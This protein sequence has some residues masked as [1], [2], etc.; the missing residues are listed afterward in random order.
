[1]NRPSS[2]TIAAEE[3]ARFTV[4]EFIE[5]A[6][7]ALGSLPGK[8]ELVDGVIVR[9]SPANYPHFTYQRQLFLKLHEIFGAG[10]D[11]FIVGQELT[12]RLGEATVRDPDIAIFRDPGMIDF[13]VDHDVLLLAV[14]VSDSTLREDLGPKKRTY[15][16]A[17]V[18]EYWVVDIR[19]QRV[20]CFTGPE[21]SGYRMERI[22]P[23]GE[24]LAVP[25]SDETITIA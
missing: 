12:V 8:I 16:E 3:P 19:A 13:I 23:F 6:G 17:A 21:G 7:G 22:V 10:I 9:M 18:P 1:M 5:M 15:A 24:P 14:E 4:E 11:G 2:S 25:G 20:H